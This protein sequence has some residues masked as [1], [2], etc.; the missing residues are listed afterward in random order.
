MEGAARGIHEGLLHTRG[1][2]AEAPYCFPAKPFGL[3]LP[4]RAPG[5]RRI[6]PVPALACLGCLR[7]QVG[8]AWQGFAHKQRGGYFR[9]PDCAPPSRLQIPYLGVSALPKDPCEQPVVAFRRGGGASCPRLENRTR[10]RPSGSSP[11][12]GMPDPLGLF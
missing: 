12:A 1:R 8:L 4:G 11:D 2:G 3:P 9:T 10:G 5:F 6:Y 7:V